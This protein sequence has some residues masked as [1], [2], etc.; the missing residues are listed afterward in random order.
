MVSLLPTIDS[1]LLAVQG[2]NYKLAEALVTASNATLHLP[3][4]VMTVRQ[5]GH[6]YMIETKVL[7]LP[8]PIL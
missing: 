6:M 3:V 5:Q 4:Q 1:N 7:A 8:F 2:G